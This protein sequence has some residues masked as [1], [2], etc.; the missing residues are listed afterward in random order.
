MC[1]GSSNKGERRKEEARRRQS[2]VF[3]FK[4]HVVLLIVDKTVCHLYI[5]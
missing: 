3:Q 5:S 4:L 1:E 2:F